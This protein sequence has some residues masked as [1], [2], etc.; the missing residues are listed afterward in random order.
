MTCV[1]LQARLGSLRLPKKALLPLEGKPVIQHAMEALGSVPAECYVLL[2]DYGSKDAFRA[3]ASGAGFELFTGPEDDVLERFGLAIEYYRPDTVIRATGDNPLVSAWLATEILARHNQSEADY[4]GFDGPPL[5]TGVEVARSD[6]LMRARK[7]SR[8]TYDHEHVM[9][10]LYRHP[11]IFRI[12]RVM[13]PAAYCMPQARVTLDTEE[14][15]VALQAVF[16]SLY[17]GAPV[18]TDELV[19]WLRKNGVCADGRVS[20]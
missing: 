10:Y 1:F 11:G 7:E 18:E 5:G 13:A 4:S 3:V 17:R 9:P 2:T 15:Y 8:E 16:R 20:A 14:D 19:A 12:H 6:A